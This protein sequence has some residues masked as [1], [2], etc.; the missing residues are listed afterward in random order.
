MMCEVGGA[1]ST[2]SLLTGEGAGQGGCSIFRGHTAA[3]CWSPDW[4]RTVPLCVAH[5]LTAH[6]RAFT[7][8][9]PASPLPLVVTLA[10]S[11]GAQ[12]HVPQPDSASAS[13]GQFL[14]MGLASHPKGLAS[15]SFGM[16]NP[17]G[18]SG[19]E[20]CMTPSAPTLLRGT[21]KYMVP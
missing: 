7:L 10:G 17:L 1:G 16:L 8:V 4:L 5:P 9:R 14:C 13:C 15:R 11:L 18:W 2:I 21:S 19:R 6:I 3:K 12:D 20:L